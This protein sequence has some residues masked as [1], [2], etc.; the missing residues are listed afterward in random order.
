MNVKKLNSLC[1]IVNAIENCVE[2]SLQNKRQMLLFVAD[3]IRDA[4]TNQ[5]STVEIL[6]SLGLYTQVPIP[7]S[8]EMSLVKDNQKLAAVKSYKERTGL[9]LMD[10]KRAIE[11]EM[12]IQGLS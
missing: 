5:R 4:I 2:L 10:S 3:E 12:K 6:D 1:N 8:Y 9:G 11:A 7:N